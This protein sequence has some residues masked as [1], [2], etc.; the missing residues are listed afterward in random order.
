MICD[1]A[2]M[3]F[4]QSNDG[5]YL[6]VVWHSLQSFQCPNFAP[7]QHSCWIWN[8]CTLVGLKHIRQALIAKRQNW[9]LY[10]AMFSRPAPARGCFIF[11]ANSTATKC[12]DAKQQNLSALWQTQAAGASNMALYLCDRFARVQ[13]LSLLWTQLKSD[14][15]LEKRY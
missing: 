2:I 14:K 11:F 10:V 3:P 1:N 4:V 5:R 13:T 8:R 9:L 7:S 15:T 6:V 12:W